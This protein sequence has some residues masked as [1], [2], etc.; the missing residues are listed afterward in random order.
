MTTRTRTRPLFDTQ[1]PADAFARPIEDHALVRQAI[2]AAQAE[3][4]A[5]LVHL[6][7]ELAI[8]V[9]TLEGIAQDVQWATRNLRDIV[10][11]QSR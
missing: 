8:V 7:E 5:E 10:N 2:E 11:P 4:H 6:R 1:A 3:V 9:E